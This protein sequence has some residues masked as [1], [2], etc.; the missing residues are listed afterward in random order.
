MQWKI[1]DY[2]LERFVDFYSEE[3]EIDWS[4]YGFENSECDQVND[5]ITTFEM[6]DSSRIFLPRYLIEEIS[7]SYIVSKLIGCGILKPHPSWE[8]L[9]ERRT[10]E[11]ENGLTIFRN[12]IEH[13]RNPIGLYALNGETLYLSSTCDK[14]EDDIS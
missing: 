11:T 13:H 3:I 1:Y 14:C 2:T 4:I 10:Y 8:Q 12:R 6:Q 9:W 7:S 5:I